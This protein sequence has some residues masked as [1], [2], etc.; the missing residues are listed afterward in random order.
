M[1][2]IHG[3]GGLVLL[4]FL[5]AMDGVAL[6][7]VTESPPAESTQTI[8]AS[9][10]QSRFQAKGLPLGSFRL[11]PTLDFGVAYDDN[12]YRTSLATLNDYYFVIN[13]ALVLRS[14]WSRDSLE[15]KASLDQYQYNKLNHET[16]TNY[17]VSATGRLDLSRGLAV[18]GTTSYE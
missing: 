13:P 14:E 2:L 11:F 3:T 17:D 5:G 12:V 1:R 4:A 9:T 6:A 18:N 10:D 15:L 7:Q 16:N 8:V